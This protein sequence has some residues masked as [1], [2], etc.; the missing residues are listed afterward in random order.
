[1]ILRRLGV[2][3]DLRIGLQIHV[4]IP[5]PFIMPSKAV[6]SLFSPRASVIF[7]ESFCKPRRYLISPLPLPAY[8]YVCLRIRNSSMIIVPRPSRMTPFNRRSF[9]PTVI[10]V[11]VSI[12][13]DFLQFATTRLECNA[14]LSLN[15]NLL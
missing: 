8:R 12:I 3:V 10:P 9:L 11:P 7:F 14:T 15:K 5:Y 1:M 13:I 4:A 2:R 6:L